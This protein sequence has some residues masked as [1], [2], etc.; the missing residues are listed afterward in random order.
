MSS[1]YAKALEGGSSAMERL[2][3]EIRRQIFRYLDTQATLMV[4]LRGIHGPPTGIEFPPVARVN[5]IMRAEFISGALESTTFSIHSGPG[6]AKFQAW[7]SRTS[8][9][10]VSSYNTGFDAVKSLSFAYFSRFRHQAMAPMAPNNDIELM[11][12]CKNLESVSMVWHG[13]ELANP[14]GDPYSVSVLR[15]CYRLDRMQGLRNLKRLRLVK[16]SVEGGES[17]ALK[18]LAEWFRSTMK[19][20]TGSPTLVTIV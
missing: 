20:A 4:Y 15:T 11:L 10:L 5:K 6:N 7:L 3:P 9:S 8:L 2:L 12:K 16:H 18:D 14:Y 19:D 17:K 1:A 13:Q